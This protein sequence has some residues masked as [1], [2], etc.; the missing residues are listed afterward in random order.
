MRGGPPSGCPHRRPAVD[1]PA[2]DENA[3]LRPLHRV[4]ERGEVGVGIDQKGGAVGLGHAPA[5]LT[6]NEHGMN[7]STF[8]PEP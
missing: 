3:L 8:G 4:T 6:R 5:G 7:L 1:V 2:D